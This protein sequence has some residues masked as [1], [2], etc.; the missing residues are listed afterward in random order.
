MTSYCRNKNLDNK[1]KQ[2]EANNGPTYRWRLFIKYEK[3]LL[4]ST[5]MSYNWA[6]NIKK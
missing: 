1:A 6:K 3:L 2:E 5:R 4:I